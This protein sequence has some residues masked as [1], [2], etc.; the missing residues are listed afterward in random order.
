M[1]LVGAGGDHMSAAGLKSVV[2][3]NVLP[4]SGFGDVLPK[5]FKLRKNFRILARALKN[6]LC[7][8]LVAID[9]PGFNMKLTA[10]A[11]R[12]NK[13]VFYVAPPQA[14]AW[15]AKRAKK[16]AN[17]QNRLALFFDFEEK[18]YKDVCCN[19]SRMQ[20]PL[21]ASTGEI[22]TEINKPLAK[23]VL[24]L[25]GSRVSQA[26]RNMSLFLD[27]A[28][29]LRDEISGEWS[30]TGLPDVVVLA[31]REGLVERL[32]RELN[33]KYRGHVPSWVRV[34]VSSANVAERFDRYRKATMVLTTPGTSTLELAL[35][36]SRCVVCTC[37]DSLTYA[38]GKRL[39]KTRWFSLPNLILGRE[40]Y[41]EFILWNRGRKSI[42]NVANALLKNIQ[43]PLDSSD[44]SLLKA[45]LNVGK[46]SEQLMSEFLAQFL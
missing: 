27:C 14:W 38:V 20:H 2:D 34:E 18:P 42:G 31:S 32:Q 12:L 46:N 44:V 1:D 28:Q 43:G 5:Y 30:V 24:L 26:C 11:N 16:L 25:P 15:K 13:P 21:V 4:V 36:G 3:Y 8:G 40:I 37:P 35:S 39:V 17:P 45:K 33:R 23:T 41:P 10:I 19:V 9:Y 29:R 7:R 22:P 6:P